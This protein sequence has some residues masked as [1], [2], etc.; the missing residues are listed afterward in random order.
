MRKLKVGALERF[1]AE[2]EAAT[3]LVFYAPLS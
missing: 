1:G 2:I 3:G